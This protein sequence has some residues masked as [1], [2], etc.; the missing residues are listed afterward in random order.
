MLFASKK[1]GQFDSVMSEFKT[2]AAK[3]RG[4]VVFVLIDSDMDENERVLEFFGLK[5]EDTPTLRLISLAQDMTKY[6]PESDELTAAVIEQ[7]VQDFF[8]KKI[9]PH[10]LTQ[11]VPA[12]WDAEPVKVLVGKNFEQ[13]AYDKSKNV[14][15][16]F[17][18][19]WCGHCKQL[20]PIYEQLAKNFADRPEF[21]IAKMDSTL[22]EVE[23][24]KIQSFP[25]IKS[26]AR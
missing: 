25:T 7:F 21:V 17:Y 20:V 8:D 26:V 13:V 11:E 12:D 9:R 1:A 10:L 23:N 19:P 24:V 2:A 4:Q 22:N 5:R 15:V 18:A 6:K 16:E 3:F 14:L